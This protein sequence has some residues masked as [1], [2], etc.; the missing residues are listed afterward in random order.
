MLKYPK[1]EDGGTPIQL[2]I[3]LL[4][5][6]IGSIFNSA[7]LQ[8]A[9]ERR[10][11]NPKNNRLLMISIASL[12]VSIGCV[13]MFFLD[14]NFRYPI[15]GL[16]FFFGI[17]FSQGLS[18]VSN[19]INDVVGSKGAYGAFVYGSY[20]FSD[21]LSCG[22]VLAFFIPIADNENVLKYSMPIFPPASLICAFVIV[23][24]RGEYKEKSNIENDKTEESDK[25]TAKKSFIDDS[26]FT[27][28]T[29]ERSHLNET[30]SNKNIV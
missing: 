2:S 18:T 12:F 24:L 21:K 19:L 9:L 1:T 5:S 6:T 30:K 26:R 13:P 4:I 17:G 29:N 8:S 11:T 14:E 25:N 20:S 7:F 23:W 28:I 10:I 16:A 27:F 15:Y 3:V 22:L